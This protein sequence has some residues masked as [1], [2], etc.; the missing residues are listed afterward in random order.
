MDD[1]NFNP[2]IQI[3]RKELTKTFVMISN[4]KKTSVEDG[5]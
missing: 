3:E 1:F 5:W 4:W 2:G